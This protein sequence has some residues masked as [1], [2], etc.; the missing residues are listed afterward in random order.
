MN[1]NYLLIGSALR[2][3]VRT[4][5]TC[6]FVGK[7]I[8]LYTHMDKNKKILLIG[9]I[10]EGVI[11]LTALILSIIIWTTIVDP[12]TIT[13]TPTAEEL[14]ALNIEKNK[15]FI[16]FFQN[17]TTAFFCIICIPV[18][19]II[20]LDFVYFAIVASKK[21]SNLTDE[22]MAALKEKAEAE[23]RAELMKEMMEE[24][25]LKENKEDK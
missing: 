7:N 17:D 22:Q 2:M 3:R 10:I 1:N 21:E 5:N 14:K 12:S 8:V 4:K 24:D 15:E 13:P 23:V 6:Y 16:A 9:G 11:L 18:F 25:L 20:A 19:V